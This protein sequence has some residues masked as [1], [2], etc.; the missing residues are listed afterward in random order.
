F[1]LAASFGTFMLAGNIFML[2]FGFAMAFGIILA[3]FVMA[4]FFTPALTARRATGA[5]GPGPGDGAGHDA[6]VAL[7]KAAGSPEPAGRH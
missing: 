1:I 4:M 2:E 7:D 6:P 3:A 5:W